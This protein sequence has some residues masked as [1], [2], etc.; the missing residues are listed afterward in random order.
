MAQGSGGFNIL[1]NVVSARD[2]S[3]QARE[4]STT[5][6]GHL[7]VAIHSPRL[8]FGEVHVES[9][10]PVF[11]CD[12]V[13]GINSALVSATTGIV[14][15]G[16]TSAT[17]TASN[18]LFKCA[19]GTTALSFATIQSR[20]R[21]RYRP[22]QG[23]IGR[24]TA[25]FS[26]P[27]AS[28]I[29]VAGIGT[30][31]S[32]YFFGYNG[33]SF[34]ILHSTGGVREMQTLTVTAGATVSSNVTITL[35][36]VAFTVPVTNSSNTSKT[37]YEI[38]TYAYS[39]WKAQQRGATVV[40]VADS[41]GNKTGT[42][43]FGAGTTGATASFA[44]TLAGV[45]ST[46]TWI[47]QSNWNGDKLDGTGPS[48]VTLVPTNG[49]VYQ[50]NVQYLGFGS[51]EFK[52]EV[53]G[54]NNNPDFVTAHTIHFP[55]TQTSTSVS[56]PAF[57]FTMAAYSAGSTT[58]VYVHSASFAGFNAGEKLLN[59]PRLTYVAETSGFVGSSASTYYPLFT[60]RNDY[61]YG[62]RA[63]Q[64]VVNLLSMAGSHD[65]ATPVT[66]FLIRNATLVGTPSFSQYAS[67]S[68]TYWDVASTTCTI[69]NNEQLIFALCIGQSSGAVHQ[70]EDEITLQPGE[71]VTLAA[72]AVTGTATYVIA[73]LNTRE[74][75]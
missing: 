11:Q 22:G 3:G 33:T 45:A 57:P 46:D 30:S 67:T 23:A 49:N 7:E 69:T 62:G 26:T 53:T 37:A 54:N 19:T 28:S 52:V 8:P 24:F 29:L 42:F 17:A 55:N 43:S 74:D 4:L 9:A 25:L 47:T 60:I 61:V 63:N 35:D 75:Q 58:N 64:S 21:L 10:H 73:S 1:T 59:G 27:A 66:F 56:Q 13:Y 40:F 39:G 31:E 12:A 2:D 51:V 38:A 15:G 65:D 44:E 41:V 71:T 70:F 36:S 50:I 34:G 68:C 48:G 16:V 5:G 14:G 32:G 72:R 18:N 20:K 6:E